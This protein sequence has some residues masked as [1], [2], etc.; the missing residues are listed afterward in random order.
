MTCLQTYLSTCCPWMLTCCKLFLVFTT[1]SWKVLRD[2]LRLKAASAIQMWATLSGNGTP[3]SILVGCSGTI[4]ESF[5]GGSWT[6]VWGDWAQGYGVW[7]RACDFRVCGSHSRH[8]RLGNL[9]VVSP[10]LAWHCMDDPQREGPSKIK[11]VSEIPMKLL[12]NFGLYTL[13]PFVI[14]CLRSSF[15]TLP[16]GSQDPLF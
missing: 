9:P 13:N 10:S 11:D 15:H 12:D 4:T 2:F 14:L 8:F 6:H 1:R 16:M 3:H 7:A 5:F